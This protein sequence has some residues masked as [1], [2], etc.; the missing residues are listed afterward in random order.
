VQPR[1]RESF[2][3]TTEKLIARRQGEVAMGLLN[4]LLPFALQRPAPGAAPVQ[5]Q[6]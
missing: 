2:S 3:G 4:A 1:L 5:D 6:E